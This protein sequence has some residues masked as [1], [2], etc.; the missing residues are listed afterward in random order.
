MF[1]LVAD[2]QDDVKEIEGLPKLKGGKTQTI[3]VEPSKLAKEYMSIF[4]KRNQKILNK[5][6]DS[7]V[8]K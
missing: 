6:V 2:Y 3:S 8:D 5:Q 7:S 1:Y 4:E